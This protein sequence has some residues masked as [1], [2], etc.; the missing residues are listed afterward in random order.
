M[1]LKISIE[2]KEAQASNYAS[3]DYGDVLYEAG[4]EG[5]IFGCKVK[6]VIIIAF[7]A[8]YFVCLYDFYCQAVAVDLS[9]TLACINKFGRDADL[10]QILHLEYRVFFKFLYEWV[11]VG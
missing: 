5:H 1:A 11:Q 7:V 8:A 4:H 10:P 6:F 9:L 2:E 3:H